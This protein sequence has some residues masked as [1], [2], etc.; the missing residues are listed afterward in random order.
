VRHIRA[1]AAVLLGLLAAT[2]AAPA[3][4]VEAVEF[5]AAE[6]PPTQFAAARAAPRPR[7][8][9]LTGRLYAPET[10][11]DRAPGGRAGPA[12]VI[13][14]GCAGRLPG[15]LEAQYAARFTARGLVVLVVDAY[16][17]RHEPARCLS[18]FIWP[19]RLAAAFGAL[20]FLA[21]REE[22]DPARVAVLGHGVGG[23][24]ALSAVGAPSG[25]TVHW[26]G[27]TGRRFAA[28]VA[29]TPPCGPAHAA[30]AAPALVVI[31]GRDAVYAPRWC[32]ALVEADPA[33][34]WP[35][36][37]QTAKLAP[38]GQRPRLLELPGAAHGFD[39]AGVGD[40]A[41]RL[42]GQPDPVRDPAADA[43]ADAAIGAFLAE[44]LAR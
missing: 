38:A 34:A 1:C 7:P 36:A 4:A 17:P 19:D 28:A 11:S 10:S 9:R 20:D 43:A 14:Q 3:Q 12:L 13:L 26:P 44:V 42:W 2:P 21:G 41:G 37:E 23:A 6:T 31:A 24:A 8:A 40:P 5:A 35:E 32:R 15:G 33:R 16:G 27:V 39:L 25:H 29:I 30:L 22:V 18:E